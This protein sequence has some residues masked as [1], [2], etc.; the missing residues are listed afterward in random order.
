[1]VE[2]LLKSK[3]TAPKYSSKKEYFFDETTK[4]RKERTN[5]FINDLKS[6]V[7]LPDNFLKANKNTKTKIAERGLIQIEEV[8]GNLKEDEGKELKKEEK[9]CFCC[10]KKENNE[11]LHLYLYYLLIAKRDKFENLLELNEKKETKLKF[12]SNKRNF[13]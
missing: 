13:F 8:L 12:I 3:E 7:K 4:E 2:S 11:M 5:K 9:V 10:F 1:M 6:L